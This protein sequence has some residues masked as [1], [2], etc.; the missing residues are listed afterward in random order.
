MTTTGKVTAVE[1]K[2]SLA[3]LLKDPLKVKNYYGKNQDFDLHTNSSA[4]ISGS[5]DHLNERLHYS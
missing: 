1:L 4:Y 2:E 3:K 5:T